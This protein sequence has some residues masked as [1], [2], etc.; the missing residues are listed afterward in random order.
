MRPTMLRKVLAMTTI[1]Q[2][3]NF[4]QTYILAS[5][6]ERIQYQRAI[7]EALNSIVQ[8]RP[9]S[10]VFL[11]S[12]RTSFV[13]ITTMSD[14]IETRGTHPAFPGVSFIQLPVGQMKLRRNLT[15]LAEVENG[16]KGNI[17]KNIKLICKYLQFYQIDESLT[18]RLDSFVL[19]D[20][21]K[22]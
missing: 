11:A 9:A 20:L 7:E 2:H 3:S 14:F 18:A 19:F 8:D 10:F 1:N 13:S 5:P 16:R 17:G 21:A 4:V 22:D 12:M 15:L 6:A